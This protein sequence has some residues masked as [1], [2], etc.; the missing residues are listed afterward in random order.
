M[1]QPTE[2][3]ENCTHEYKIFFLCASGIL[4]CQ[5][6]AMP[7]PTKITTRQILKQTR[8]SCR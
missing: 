5:W 6:M 4:L 1:E 2:A 3:L 7:Y 8:L